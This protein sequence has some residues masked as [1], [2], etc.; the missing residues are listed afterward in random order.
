MRAPYPAAAF[1]KVKTTHAWRATGHRPD[2]LPFLGLNVLVGNMGTLTP[3]PPPSPGRGKDSRAV[4]LQG[5]LETH[6]GTF[7]P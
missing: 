6:M 2:D 4:W 5:T 7:Q 1:P 3:A